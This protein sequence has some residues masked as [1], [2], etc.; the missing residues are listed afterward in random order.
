MI[1]FK[2]LS[3]SMVRNSSKPDSGNETLARNQIGFPSSLFRDALADKLASGKPS[4]TSTSGY[5]NPNKYQ[6]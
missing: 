1:E 4:V 2:G 3:F 6:L 5:L